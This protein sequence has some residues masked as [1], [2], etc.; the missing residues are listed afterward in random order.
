M[1]SV[2]VPRGTTLEPVPVGPA[3]R[4]DEATSLVN[5]ILGLV[6]GADFAVCDFAFGK[7]N[8]YYECGIRH[9][10]GKPTVHLA[11]RD[12]PLPFDVKMGPSWGALHEVKFE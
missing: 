5:R 9:C 6:L 11:R 7:P 3:D 8:V 10:T 12:E 4:I 2:Y 1:L